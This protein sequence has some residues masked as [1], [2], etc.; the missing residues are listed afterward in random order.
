MTKEKGDEV[1][2]N[3]YYDDFEIGQTYPMFEYSISAEDMA[4]HRASYECLFEGM[5]DTEPADDETIVSPFAVNSF[6]AIRAAFGMPDGVLHARETLHLH[7]P[8]RVTDQLR[9]ELS[10]LDKYERNGRPFIVFRHRVMRQESELV[11][12]ID[13]TIC[14]IR[15]EREEK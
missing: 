2:V 12:D 3:L 9:V 13:R 7:A 4:V 1:G 6:L 5:P 10:I 11:M 14:W 15:K 8:A